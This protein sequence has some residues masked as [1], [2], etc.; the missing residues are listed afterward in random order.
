MEQE[1]ASAINVSAIFQDLFINYREAEEGLEYEQELGQFSLTTEHFTTHMDGLDRNVELD[2]EQTKRLTS[3]I[4]GMRRGLPCY[5]SG[6]IFVCNHDGR[7][8]LM[9]ALISGPVDTPYAHGL[10]LFDISCSNGFP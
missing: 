1:G 8:D 10:Y 6:S 3:E 4:K 7:L 9:K 5:S 2:L